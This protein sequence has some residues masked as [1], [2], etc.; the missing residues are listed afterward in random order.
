MNGIEQGVW[1]VNKTL[2]EILAPKFDSPS[3]RVQ[4][5]TTGLQESRFMD[6]IQLGG[7]PA[8]SF[9]Q[10]EPNGVKAVRNHK[11]VGPILIDACNKLGVISD[12]ETVYREVINNDELACV[13]ARLILYADSN[14]LPQVGDSDGAFKCYVRNWRPG[15]YAR[16]TQT[17][18]DAIQTKW[19]KNYAVAQDYANG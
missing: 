16:G 12:W 13:V 15:A 5:L 2:T 17:Q 18:K 7:G 9:W 3:A 10:E 8:H 6:R 4:L 14:P 1:V 11:V 19:R